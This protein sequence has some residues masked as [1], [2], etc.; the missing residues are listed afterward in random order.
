VNLQNIIIIGFRKGKVASHK[1]KNLKIVSKAPYHLALSGGGSI[2][3]PSK[4]INFF[5]VF[6]IVLLV[7]GT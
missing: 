4:G 2:R 5:Q 1:I 7:Q 3:G 6:I